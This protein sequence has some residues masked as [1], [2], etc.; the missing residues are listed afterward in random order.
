MHVH[1]P[2]KVWE[3]NVM[4]GTQTWCHGTHVSMKLFKGG[5]VDMGCQVDINSCTDACT[6]INNMWDQ[7][8]DDWNTHAV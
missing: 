6:Y 3:Q 4:T 5:G 7:E 1:I 2:T 8:G